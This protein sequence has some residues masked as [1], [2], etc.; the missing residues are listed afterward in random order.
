MEK[1]S[2][3][4]LKYIENFLKSTLKSLSLIG[5]LEFS[6]R[7]MQKMNTLIATENQ[8]NLLFRLIV[9]Q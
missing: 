1:N 3:H 9:I 2:Q 6:L 5:D 8:G 7:P 4:I